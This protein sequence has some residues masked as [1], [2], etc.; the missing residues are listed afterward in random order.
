MTFERIIFEAA[1]YKNKLTYKPYF[2]IELDDSCSRRI[3]EEKFAEDL[4]QIFL[5]N[6]GI[7]LF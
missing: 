4:S 7:C 3:A 1:I 5:T 2:L 6:L